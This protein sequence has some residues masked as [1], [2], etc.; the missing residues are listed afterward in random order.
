[1]GLAGRVDSNPLARWLGYEESELE[2]GVHAEILLETARTE[3]RAAILIILLALGFG[4]W[5]AFDGSIFR[6]VTLFALLTVVPILIDSGLRR[7]AAQRITKVGPHPQ[8]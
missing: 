2:P 8:R 7:G 4:L 5:F 6:A 3:A 1:M